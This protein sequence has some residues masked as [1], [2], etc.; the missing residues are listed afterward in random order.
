VQP[1]FLLFLAVGFASYTFSVAEA[2]GH[3]GIWWGIGG[4]LL[5]P[6]AFLASLGLPD[7]QT[8]K[9]LRHI[10]ANQEIDR[11]GEPKVRQRAQT[12]SYDNT[13]YN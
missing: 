3:D 11:L 1:V 10:A 12:A 2:K 13:E 7:L 8:R 6:L 4:F 9:Y 5:G